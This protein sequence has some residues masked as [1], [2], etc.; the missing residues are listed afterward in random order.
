MQSN[1][2]SELK[3]TVR[4]LGTVLGE[5]IKA[6]L[7][8]EWLERIEQIRLDGRG[9]YQGD[10]DCSENL[11]QTF[12]TLSDSDL[13]TVGRAFAQFLNLGNIAEQE[14]NSAMNVDASIDTLFNHL[15]KAQLSTENVEK[16]HLQ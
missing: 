14:Y 1:Y 8:D 16:A 6:Q 3:D 7:G 11:K 9:S 13:L 12:K 4:Y 15:D 5:T 2:D 10:T